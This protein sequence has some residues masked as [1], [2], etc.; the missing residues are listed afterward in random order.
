MIKFGLTVQECCDTLLI[1][2]RNA[3]ITCPDTVVNFTMFDLQPTVVTHT[4]C[5][6]YIFRIERMMVHFE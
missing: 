4:Q 6:S 1:I 5:E 2:S 3:H